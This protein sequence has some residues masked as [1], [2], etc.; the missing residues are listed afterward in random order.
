M[1]LVKEDLEKTLEIIRVRG[2]LSLNTT[3][4][5]TILLLAR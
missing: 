5:T 4:M 2:N 1:G 3:A